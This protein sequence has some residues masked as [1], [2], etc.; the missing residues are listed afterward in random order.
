MKARILAALVALGLSGCANQDGP[1]LINVFKPLVD[2]TTDTDL[3]KY[4]GSGSLDVAAGNP[5]YGLGFVISPNGAAT[6]PPDIVVGGQIVQPGDFN[7]AI[8]TE[9][10]IT[11]RTSRRLTKTPAVFV[12]PAHVSTQVGGD[13]GMRAQVLSSEIGSLLFDE[14][15]PF[16]AGDSDIDQIDLNVDIELRGE[17]SASKSPF[18]SGTA[19]FPIRV[20]R[21]SPTPCSGHE[22]F[23]THVVGDACT[24]I[25]QTSDYGFTPA[26]PTC[27]DPA[28]TPGC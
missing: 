20:F 8:V 25:G 7:R 13:I 19:T 2:C 5:T 18:S 4:I 3:T 22:R 24:Y 11:Y 16:T 15:T 14:L 1:Y 23:R 21:S 17:Y 10:D 27:C 12:V 6:P 26:P 28:V 9:F